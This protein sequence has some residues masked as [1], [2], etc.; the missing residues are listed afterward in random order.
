MTRKGG[1][2]KDMKNINL[3]VEMADNRKDGEGEFMWMAI[4]I[5]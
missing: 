1:V 3:R 5:N 2:E 4:G